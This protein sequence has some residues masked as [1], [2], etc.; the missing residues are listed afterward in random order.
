MGRPKPTRNM[1]LGKSTVAVRI[2]GVCQGRTTLG[3]LT[4]ERMVCRGCRSTVELGHYQVSVRSDGR[5][6]VLMGAWQVP[7]DS[8][9]SPGLAT[10]TSS[11][12]IT[13]KEFIQIVSV[14][15]KVWSLD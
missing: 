2:R 15:L 1:F 7:V 12:V 11:P 9:V 8:A 5:D 6:R 10:L 4:K 3:N 13:L 14:V